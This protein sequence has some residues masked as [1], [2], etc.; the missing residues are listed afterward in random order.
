MKT[1]AGR[2]NKGTDPLSAHGCWN[3]TGRRPPSRGVIAGARHSRRPRHRYHRSGASMPSLSIRDEACATPSVTTR[4]PESPA[5]Q[6]TLRAVEWSRM[7]RGQGHTE[8]TLRAELRPPT[9]L[10]VSRFGGGHARSSNPGIPAIA[11]WRNEFLAVCPR[12]VP[13]QSGGVRR[14]APAPLRHK[15]LRGGPN[16]RGNCCCLRREVP[17]SGLVRGGVVAT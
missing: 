13:V 10:V 11:F 14:R 3:T 1:G 2:A 17:S 6:P 5:S 9:R 15:V 8:D 16:R 12:C 4:Q 7:G